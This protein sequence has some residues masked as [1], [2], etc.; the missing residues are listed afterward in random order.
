MTAGLDLW[1]QH[2][3]NVGSGLVTGVLVGLERG[4]NLKAIGSPESAPSACSDWV[5]E[6][7]A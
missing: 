3:L 5:R 4:F 1:A 7:L 2:A 6:S